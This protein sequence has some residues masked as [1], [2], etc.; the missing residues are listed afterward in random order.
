MSDTMRHA[1]GK[2][3]RGAGVLDGP[4]M[5]TIII[6]GSLKTTLSFAD[7]IALILTYSN[8]VRII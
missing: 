2:G 7:L 5:I 6:L 8:G 4:R 1:T 3:K